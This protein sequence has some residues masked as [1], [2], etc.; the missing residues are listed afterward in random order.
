MY[1][2]ELLESKNRINGYIGQI[3]SQNL[4]PDGIIR[5]FDYEVMHNDMYGKIGH[6]SGG[7]W[8]R[9]FEKDLQEWN[10]SAYEKGTRPFRLQFAIGLLYSSQLHG[11]CNI[12][13]WNL[14]K[15]V[16]E[17]DRD[18]FTALLETERVKCDFSIL[19]HLPV[20][21]FYVDFRNAPI[22][23]T[24]HYED[25]QGIIVRAKGNSEFSIT[26]IDKNTSYGP[27]SALTY[28]PAS[29]KRDFYDGEYRFVTIFLNP[30]KESATK[31]NALEELGV[32]ISVNDPV[33]ALD[34]FSEVMRDII[35]FTVQFLMFLASRAKDI[36]PVKKISVRSE[37]NDDIDKWKV[38][39]NYG[40][41]FR[42]IERKRELYEQFLN[43]P[44]NPVEKKRPRPYLRSAHW[45]RY[46]CGNANQKHI[47]TR[48]IEPTFCNGTMDD[49]VTS[50]HEVVQKA[51]SGSSGEECISEY[52]TKM[53]VSFHREAAV[54][55][56]GHTRRFDFA[57]KKGTKTMFIEFDGEQHFRPVEKFEGE[58]G[59]K[60]RRQA[61][62][63]KNKYVRKNRIPLLRIR[64]DQKKD[65]P[66]LIDA[67]FQS[68]TVHSVNSVLSNEEYYKI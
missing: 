7:T 6:E 40:K 25:V 12:R 26:V 52:L 27:K 32:S 53:N 51:A 46:W 38:G 45:H 15:K 35:I 48:W 5:Q 42:L 10:V 4:N 24:N 28:S 29:W 65:I 16:Y 60:D 8:L 33:S 63:E 62:R 37:R 58:Q 36:T 57:V 22:G 9:T 3:F 41:K 54:N 49:I 13:Y 31:E 67:F 43:T 20:P 59:F 55:I 56:K 14:Y 18:F 34:R 44:D 17:I 11:F 68:P 47:E 19:S 61:D 2:Q 21:C 1:L 66:E 23:I 30:Q 64:Y 50:I 39:E